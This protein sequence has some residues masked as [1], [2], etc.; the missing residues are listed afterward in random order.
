M[1]NKTYKLFISPR[2]AF[3]QIRKIRSLRDIGY[4]LRGLK[5]VSGHLKD[6]SGSK[7]EK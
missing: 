7:W 1:C 5:A 6:F 2:Y 4:A 3:S